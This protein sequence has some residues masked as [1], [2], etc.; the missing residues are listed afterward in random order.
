MNIKVKTTVGATIEK[1]WTAWTKPEHI[2]HW[3]F[4]SDDWQCPAA[5]IDLIVG[6]KFKYRMEAK[7]ASMGFDFAGTFTAIKPGQEI[8]F[9]LDDDRN[10]AVSFEESDRGVI[11]IETFEAENELA[12]DQQR[13]G[14][15]SILDN[16]KAYVE[17]N[18][19]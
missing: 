5:E 12:G 1:V 16:F 7:D 19:T 4:A 13:R 11:V 8:Q 18:V 9:V 3:N 6:G 2:V 17:A 15:Q 10:V 14:W